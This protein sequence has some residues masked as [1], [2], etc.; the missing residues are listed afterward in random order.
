MSPDYLTLF[1]PGSKRDTPELLMYIKLIIVFTPNLE[2]SP[3]SEVI[4]YMEVQHSSEW[5]YNNDQRKMINYSVWCFWSLFHFF[6]FTVPD[7]KCHRQK[8]CMLFI[9]CIKQVV[10]VLAYAY[11]I[12]HIKWR[13]LR[14]LLI[15][16]CFFLLIL[17]SVL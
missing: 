3:N 8:W 4:Q 2:F 6:H 14:V 1:C 13:R 7:N 9:T 16:I 11:V 17:V 12:A 10:C 15:W 5:K